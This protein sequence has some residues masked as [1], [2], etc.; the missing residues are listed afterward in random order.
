[1]KF[2]KKNVITQKFYL[3]KR[4]NY[5]YVDSSRAPNTSYYYVCLEGP[6][7]SE[8]KQL[9]A[10]K[11]WTNHKHVKF[12]VNKPGYYRNLPT[13]SPRFESWDE[14]RRCSVIPSWDCLEQPSFV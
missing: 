11:S 6:K 7:S 8:C 2:G 9:Y 5:F 14:R 3:P 12:Y 4:G 1:A 13:E 10:G